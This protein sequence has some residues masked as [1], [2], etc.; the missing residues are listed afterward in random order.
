MHLEQ[1]T[2]VWVES[3]IAA[4][5]SSC[6]LK[7]WPVCVSNVDQTDGVDI[8]KSGLTAKAENILD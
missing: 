5:A 4:H 2:G 8:C 6:K 7:Q 1:V 3:N